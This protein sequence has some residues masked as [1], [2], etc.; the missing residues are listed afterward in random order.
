MIDIRDISTKED[1]EYFKSLSNDKITVALFHASWC[2]PC[3]VLE[4]TLKNLDPEKIGNTL[5]GELD[6]DNENL[7]DVIADN[8]VRNVPVMVF[9]K[10]GFEANRIVG[11]VPVTEIYNMINKLSDD[12]VVD[13][14]N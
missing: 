8:R 6:V 10:N 1:F 5:F 13:N 14:T 2:G 11:N 4:G 7:E 9:F 3:R 12:A